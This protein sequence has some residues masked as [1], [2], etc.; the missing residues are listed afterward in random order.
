LT[1]WD[2][3]FPFLGEGAIFAPLEKTAGVGTLQMGETSGSREGGNELRASI[4]GQKVNKKKE[5]S[6]GQESLGHAQKTESARALSS[7]ALFLKGPGV[8]GR[9]TEGQRG[10]LAPTLTQDR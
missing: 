8:V 10:K 5:T 1:F 9:M 3:P 6:T 7:K 2:D 4:A